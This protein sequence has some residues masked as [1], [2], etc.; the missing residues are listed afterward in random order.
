[1][2]RQRGPDR[3]REHHAC[4][5]WDAAA[6][7]RRMPPAYDMNPVSLL[8]KQQAPAISANEPTA[9]M[10]REASGNRDLM[11]ARREMAREFLHHH[12]RRVPLR[13]EHLRG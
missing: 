12:G 7:G 3:L 11:P 1:M 13:R 5:K 8:A 6:F 9:G 2:C 4:A 10:M